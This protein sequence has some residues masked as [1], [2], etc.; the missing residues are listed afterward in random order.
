MKKQLIAA[1]I[2]GAL[3]SVA[4]AEETTVI[5]FNDLDTNKDDALSVEEANS[6]PGITAQW[7]MLDMDGNGQLNRGEYDGYMMPAPAS[8]AVENE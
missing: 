4:G 5:Q 8:G 1:V 2:L 3:S 7:S 6:L